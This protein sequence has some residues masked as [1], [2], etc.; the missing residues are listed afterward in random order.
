MA[1][2]TGRAGKITER[3]HEIFTDLFF[4]GAMSEPQIARAYFTSSSRAHVRLYSLKKKRYLGN[5][6]VGSAP[7]LW[8]LTPEARERQAGILDADPSDF[9]A[10]I[11]PAPNRVHH[12]IETVELYIAL[13]H[14]LDEILGPFPAW[15]WRSEK[16]AHDDYISAG[17][18]RHHRPDAQLEFPG[19]LFFIERQTKKARSGPVVLDEKVGNYRRYIENVIHRASEAEVL[20]ACD[21]RRDVDS[22]RRAGERYG[23][24]VI[25]GTP[26]VIVDYI[27]DIARQTAKDLNS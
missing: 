18:E 14:K 11:S 12:L 16:A 20:F 15:S 4:C 8:Y 3:D 13:R 27:L 5:E 6:R 2:L 25:A 21:E 9:E 1:L 24:S 19:A 22:A 10:A 7:M 17:E 26:T 23:V